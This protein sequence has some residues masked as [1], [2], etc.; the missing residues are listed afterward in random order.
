MKLKWALI[1]PVILFTC[2]GPSDLYPK[3]WRMV[4]VADLQLKVFP[5]ILIYGSLIW[6]LLAK[7]KTIRSGLTE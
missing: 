6:E 3:S 2:L 4:I 5:C 7:P 1:V